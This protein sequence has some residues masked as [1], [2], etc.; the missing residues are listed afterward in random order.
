MSIKGL[1]KK[2]SEF[3]NFFIILIF[4]IL[5]LIINLKKSNENLEKFDKFHFNS[6]LNLKEHSFIKSDIHSIWNTASIFLNHDREGKKFFESGR[7]Y[8]RS[9]LPPIIVYIYFKLV[10]EDIKDVGNYTNEYVTG[11]KYK[12]NNSKFGLIIFQNI[13][14]FLSLVIF[15]FNTKSFIPKNI[16]TIIILF[17]CFE[18]TIS[19]WHTN[20]FTESIFLSLMILLI[21]FLYNIKNTLISFFFLGLFVGVIYMQKNL[22]LYLIVPICIILF[23]VFKINALKNL[24]YLLLGF[25]IPIIFIGVHNNIRSGEFYFVPKH[26]KTAPYSYIQH[27]IISN[28]LSI[29]ETESLEIIKKNEENWIFKNNIDLNYELDRRKF[30]KYKQKIFIKAALDEPVF[31]LKYIVW[32]IMQSGILDPN[33]SYTFF[34]YQNNEKFWKYDNFR[35]NLY[36]KIIYSSLIYSISLLGLFVLF[37]HRNRKLITVSSTLIVFLTVVLGWVGVS[38]YFIPNLVPLSI[39]F[40]FGLNHI[41]ER[42]HILRN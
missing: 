39:F 26:M 21:T 18:P 10:D 11:V 2:F 20:F 3:N 24:P 30:Y 4:I 14:Y 36:Y 37:K 8:A 19:Q 1:I 16:L 32:K 40:G 35:K 31:T 5:S 7:E 38:R 25:S 15:Y 13:F 42:M 23:F 17:L 34:K 33:Y 6:Y 22:G 29:S 12:L 41:L 28:K 9:Y 27:K